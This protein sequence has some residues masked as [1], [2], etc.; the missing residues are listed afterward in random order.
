MEI[1]VIQKEKILCVMKDYDTKQW[2]SIMKKSL[3]IETKYD[4]IGKEFYNELKKRNVNCRKKFF[5]IE[6]YE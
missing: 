1:D 5:T 6:F 3:K 2:L 4:P